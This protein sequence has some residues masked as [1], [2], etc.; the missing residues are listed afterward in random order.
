MDCTEFNAIF[1]RL[2]HF[3]AS[4]TIEINR[5]KL[6]GLIWSNNVYISDFVFSFI[7]IHIAFTAGLVESSGRLP[8]DGSPAG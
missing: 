6:I 4:T 5:N 3:C 2:L 8:P 7:H 1:E